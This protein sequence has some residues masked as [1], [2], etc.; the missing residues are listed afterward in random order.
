MSATIRLVKP[1]L[2]RLHPTA[3]E[4]R[5]I[6]ITGNDVA[7]RNQWKAKLLESPLNYIKRA[8]CRVISLSSDLQGATYN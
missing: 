1:P 6:V 8:K 2:H 4:K 3:N 7:I 5:G